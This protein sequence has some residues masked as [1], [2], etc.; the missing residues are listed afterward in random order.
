MSNLAS[1]CTPLTGAGRMKKHESLNDS[2]IS[3]DSITSD[4]IKIL[5][6]IKGDEE[7]EKYPSDTSLGAKVSLAEMLETA[8]QSINEKVARIRGLISE[9]GGLIF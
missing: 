4:L 6:E 7:T 1:T 9:I 5:L 2:I 8:P 3:I